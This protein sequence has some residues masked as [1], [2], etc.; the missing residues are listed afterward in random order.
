MFPLYQQTPVPA[1]TKLFAYKSFNAIKISMTSYASIDYLK[2]SSPK[3]YFLTVI[4]GVV[5]LHLFW[6]EWCMKSQA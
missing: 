6:E 2:N 3:E 5:G 4:H 1:N